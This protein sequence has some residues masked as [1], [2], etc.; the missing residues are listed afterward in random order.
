VNELEPRLR[1]LGIAFPGEPNLVP[2]VLAQLQGR[3]PFPWRRAAAL[4]LAI[5]AVAIA[6][7]FAVPQARTTI[8]HWFHLG[9]ASVERVETLPRAAERRQAATLGRPLAR[10]AAERAVGFRLVLPPLAHGM[11]RVYVLAD[12]LA[13]VF[14]KRRGTAVLLSEFRSFGPGTL[15]KLVDPGVRIERVSVDGRPGL[16]LTGAPH[17]L[18][19]FDE[20]GVREQQLLIRGNVL[21]W[22]RGPLTLR[23]EGKLTRSEALDFA[24]SVH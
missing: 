22:V 4:A 12:S 21:L 11:P 1:A 13:T 8:L 5:V 24:R 10:A 14:V 19:Y 2:G 17:V 23:L 20:T 18:R 3:K 15:D 9:G 16:W 6:A 7:A